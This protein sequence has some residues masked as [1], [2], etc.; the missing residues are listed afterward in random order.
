[1]IPIFVLAFLSPLSTYA[2]QE[3]LAPNSAVHGGRLEAT[4]YGESGSEYFGSNETNSL[5]Q[6]R[7]LGFGL[8][9]SLWLGGRPGATEPHGAVLLLGATSELKALKSTLCGYECKPNNGT[10]I[11]G[12]YSGFR[13][14][15]GYDGNWFGFRAGGLIA[16]GNAV[17]T[18]TLASPDIAFRIGPR[19]DGWLSLGVG[20]Y[21]APTSLRP[22]FYAGVSFLPV[23]GLTA[24]LHAGLHA[25]HGTLGATITQLDPRYDFTL[26]YQLTHAVSIS[27]GI[28]DQSSAYGNDVYEG[29]LSTSVG[30]LD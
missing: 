1:L 26:E 8:L 27:A 18:D 6:E 9:G 17:A 7:A 23:R 3:P 28:V 5:Y 24:S 29:H 22:G 15:A 4:I 30:F 16:G 25:D 12:N 21:D 10:F 14:G 19:S 13:L 2:Q 11:A 20:A